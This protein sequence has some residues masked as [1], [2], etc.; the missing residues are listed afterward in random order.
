MCQ[1]AEENFLLYFNGL[2]KIYQFIR[3][4]SKEGV[5]HCRQP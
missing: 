1:T 5:N 2:E 3:C 4:W